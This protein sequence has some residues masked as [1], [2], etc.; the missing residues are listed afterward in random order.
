MLMLSGVLSP[1]FTVMPSGNFSEDEN[2]VNSFSIFN[3]WSL[4]LL[5]PD[6]S[7]TVTWAQMTMMKPTMMNR[8]W[9]SDSSLL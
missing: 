3:A 4:C 9:S 8:L 2:G 1:D 6:P 7:A 5:Q